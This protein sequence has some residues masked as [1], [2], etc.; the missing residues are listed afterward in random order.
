M[1]PWRTEGVLLHQPSVNVKHT[2]IELNVSIENNRRDWKISFFS[3]K[4]KDSVSDRN[5]V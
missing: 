4:I 1:K 3:I 5:L 2:L